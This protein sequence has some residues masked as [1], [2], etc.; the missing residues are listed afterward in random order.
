MKLSSFNNIHE[1]KRGFVLGTG[2]SINIILDEY[3]FVSD[4]LYN[5]I[6]VG[7]KHVHTL[8][9]VNYM[10]SIDTGYYTNHYK[11]IVDKK[12]IKFIPKVFIKDID[13]TVD[14]TLVQIPY[15]NSV[16]KGGKMPPETLPTSFDNLCIDSATGV[17]ALRIAYMMGLNPIYLLGIDSALY[18]SNSHFHHEYKGVRTNKHM[19]SMG[20]DF[21]PT[22]K[23]MQNKETEIISLSP[24]SYFN[25]LVP[26]VDIRQ[27]EF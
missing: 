8:F 15:S 12:F 19:V 25:P 16:N 27:I 13:V 5:E 3:K 22:I 4:L 9:P 24:I 23:A 21:P 11:E 14:K 10:V 26:Y 1:G 20:K 7:C 2:P 17:V 18:K 6:V